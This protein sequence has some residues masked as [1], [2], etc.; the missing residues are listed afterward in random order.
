ME[1]RTADRQTIGKQGEEVAC[2]LLQKMGHKIVERN[3]RS[4][5]LEV[6]LVTKDEKGIH[7]VEVKTR[8]QN[9]QAAPQDCVDLAKQKKI[10]KAAKNYPVRQKFG[11][12]EIFFDIVAVTF[13]GESVDTEYFPQAFIPLYI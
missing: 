10:A 7:F 2:R 6:D 8:R 4:G 11:D 13:T 5:H 12:T 9:I 3:W 1:D